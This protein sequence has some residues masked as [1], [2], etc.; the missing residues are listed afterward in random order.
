MEKNGAVSADT[1]GQCCGGNCHSKE[2]TDGSNHMTGRFPQTEAQADSLDGDITKQAV[3]A[4]EQASNP[5]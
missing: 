3:D 4:V 2:A 1:P 5:E